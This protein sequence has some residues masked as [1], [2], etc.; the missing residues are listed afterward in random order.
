MPTTKPSSP[1]GLDAV[2]YMVKDLPRARK[3]YEEAL[4]FE[5][6][7]VND[8]GEWQGVEYELPTGQ[9]FGLGKSASSPWRQCGGAMIAV[10]NVEEL[11]K[12]VIMFGG[13]ILMDV[14]ESPVCFTSWCEDSEGNSFSL[15]RRKDGTAG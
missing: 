9:T 15:H 14:S 5:P 8:F 13:K 10:A 3:F 6:T 2:Y 1:R 11:T 7:V 12:R 4:G